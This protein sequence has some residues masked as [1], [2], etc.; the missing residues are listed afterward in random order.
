MAGMASFCQYH[1]NCDCPSDE[2]W[3][4]LESSWTLENL[5]VMLLTRYK[6]WVFTFK[7]ERISLPPDWWLELHFPV[8]K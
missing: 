7:H 8:S 4:V 5:K 3:E 2:L 1:Y 6:N